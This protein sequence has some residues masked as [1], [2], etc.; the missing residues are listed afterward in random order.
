MAVTLLTGLTT[1]GQPSSPARFDHHPAPGGPIVRFDIPDPRRDGRRFADPARYREL[2][3]QIE[4]SRPN[5]PPGSTIHGPA[6]S[7]GGSNSRASKGGPLQATFKYTA[8][9]PNAII[10]LGCQKAHVVEAN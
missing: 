2:L 10:F 7:K 4:S 5:S 3:E 8:P 6:N 1:F 9:E